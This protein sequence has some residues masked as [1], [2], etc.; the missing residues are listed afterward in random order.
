MAEEACDDQY[1]AMED[2]LDCALVAMDPK[3]GYVKA[4]VGG[5]QFK[6]QRLL[7]RAVNSRQPGSS[8]KPL[9]VYGAALQKSY[10]LHGNHSGR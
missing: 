2:G 9:S 7:N 5:R 10:E 1:W 3:T 8:I 4:M 6:G